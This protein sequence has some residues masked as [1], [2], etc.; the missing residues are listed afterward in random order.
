MSTAAAAPTMNSSVPGTRHTSRAVAARTTCARPAAM[1]CSTAS[2][3]TDRPLSRRQR[4]GLPLS[5]I[6]LRALAGLAAAAANQAAAQ[7]AAPACGG[8]TIAAGEVAR[9]IDGKTF[10]LSDGR[11]A[12]LAAIEAPPVSAADPNEEHAAIGQA[13]KTALE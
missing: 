4:Q 3:P 2:R 9:V 13:A 12:R 7:P 10:V 1:A 6:L 5:A 8:A 11:E